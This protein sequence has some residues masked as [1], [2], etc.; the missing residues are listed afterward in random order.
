MTAARERIESVLRHLRQR[1]EKQQQ[2]T[3]AWQRARSR[4]LLIAQTLLEGTEATVRLDDDRL[5]LESRHGSNAQFVFDAKQLALIGKR[6]QKAT[7]KT[8]VE[9]FFSL[10]I[11][12][13]PRPQGAAPGQ[14]GPGQAEGIRELTPQVGSQEAFEKAVADWFEWSHM[15]PGAPQAGA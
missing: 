11:E 8:F 13:T 9:T 1:Q 7:E 15:G 2:A 3:G 6:T 4:C 12:P 10:R 5:I 14:W